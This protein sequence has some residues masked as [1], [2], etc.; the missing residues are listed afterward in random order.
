MR[1]KALRFYH[2]SCSQH[3]GEGGGPN[4]ADNRPFLRN[5]EAAFLCQESPSGW[6]GEF[7]AMKGFGEHS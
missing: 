1:R 2:G 4:P 6:H 7:R 3:R 5:S